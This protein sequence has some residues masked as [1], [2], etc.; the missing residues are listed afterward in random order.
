MEIKDKLVTVEDLAAYDNARGSSGG[1]SGGSSLEL[2]GEAPMKYWPSGSGPAD[3]PRSDF[4]D[5]VMTQSWCGF[6]ID[7]SDID[8]PSIGEI[9]FSMMVRTG[10]A[11]P[12]SDGNI[13]Y[14]YTRR[15]D[16]SVYDDGTEDE[17]E[18]YSTMYYNDYRP[19]VVKRLVN[20]SDTK[21]N[22]GQNTYDSRY[23]RIDYFPKL[24]K[25]ALSFMNDDMMIVSGGWTYPPFNTITHE[26]LQTLVETSKEDMA[27]NT[28]YDSQETTIKI[29]KA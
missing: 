24:K 25:A 10:D 23:V 26:Y 19:K 18:F 6:E 13:H 8:M 4:A 20:V 16:I 14:L 2:I 15:V 1:S 29:Y 5:N 21:I 11:P 27:N 12:Y 3:P 7:L 17:Y 22:L 28:P 9:V